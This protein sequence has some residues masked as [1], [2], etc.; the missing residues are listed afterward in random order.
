MINEILQL[1]SAI[2]LM[3]FMIKGV[4]KIMDKYIPKQDPQ[5]SPA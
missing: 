1:V 4:N 5:S 2:A 3:I